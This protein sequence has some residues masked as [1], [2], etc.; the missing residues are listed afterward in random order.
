MRRAMPN[1]P[2]RGA[3]T[4]TRVS[5]PP[6]RPITP[7][8]TMSSFLSSG[9]RMAQMFMETPAPRSIAQH[10]GNHIRKHEPIYR[11]HDQQMRPGSTLESRGSFDDTSIPEVVSYIAHNEPR[12]VYGSVANPDD[13]INGFLKDKELEDGKSGLLVAVPEQSMDRGALYQPIIDYVNGN[14]SVPANFLSNFIK[15]EEVFVT[16]VKA[17]EA[18]FYTRDLKSLFDGNT[19]TNTLATEENGLPREMTLSELVDTDYIKEIYS[20][21]QKVKDNH[22]IA[23]QLDDVEPSDDYTHGMRM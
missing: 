10:A 13:L 20:E 11:I 8:R 5:S 3:S 15:E 22:V 14:D 23:G 4:P 1:R 9:A 17:E 2:S 12:P 19:V 6:R 7:Q 21:F 18:I 16:E